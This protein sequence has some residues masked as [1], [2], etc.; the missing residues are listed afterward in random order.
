MKNLDL[1]ELFEKHDSL[2][3]SPQRS[4]L[5]REIRKV[6]QNFI[7]ELDYVG[8]IDMLR[9][10]GDYEKGRLL[11]DLLNKHEDSS[12][13]V[14][15]FS[16]SNMRFYKQLYEEEKSKY[17]GDE[18]ALCTDVRLIFDEKL[19]AFLSK[20]GEDEDLAYVQKLTDG[21]YWLESNE[22]SKKVF[23]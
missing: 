16:T 15:A 12:L 2:P 11:L 7:K 14:L 17:D 21:A 8:I 10:L 3:K 4:K 19:C 1:K 22:K 13:F 6:K 20:H 18:E 23:L 5:S 9:Y